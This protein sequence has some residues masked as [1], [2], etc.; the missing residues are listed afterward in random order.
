LGRNQFVELGTVEAAEIPIHD[1]PAVSEA[2]E[3]Q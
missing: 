1:S 3:A 2:D